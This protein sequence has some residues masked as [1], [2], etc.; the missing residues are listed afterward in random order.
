MRIQISHDTVY[1]YDQPVRTLTQLLRLTP[2]DHDGQHVLRWRIEP[3]VDGRLRQREDAF[4]N[5]LHV[6][7]PTVPLR[8]SP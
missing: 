5:I 8:R 2:R 4:G 1:R 7:P 3:S 6:F